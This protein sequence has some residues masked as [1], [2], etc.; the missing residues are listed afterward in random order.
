MFE[1]V[2]RQLL[3]KNSTTFRFTVNKIQESLEINTI[4][5]ILR[6]TIV[7][8]VLNFFIWGVFILSPVKNVIT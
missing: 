1:N 5:F 8:E 6:F 2:L 7:N 3:K 4:R